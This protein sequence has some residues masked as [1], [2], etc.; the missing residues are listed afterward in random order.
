[1]M[2]KIQHPWQVGPTELIE[3]ALERMHNGEDFDRRLAF[4][5][6]DVGVETL[7]KTYLTLPDGVTQFQIKRSERYAAVDGN[8]HELL[9]GVQSANPKKASVINFA[10]IEHYH[11]LRNTLYHQGNQVTAV[12]LNQLDGYAKLAVNLLREYLDVNLSPKLKRPFSAGSV[13]T[14]NKDGHEPE[15]RRH[16]TSSM[17]FAD[18]EKK[19]K[20]DEI[21]I[22][23]HLYEFTKQN[24]S[25]VRMGTGA[26]S[27]SFTFI[28]IRNDTSGS[29]FSV[30]SNGDFTVNLGYLGKVCSQEE[31]DR[32]RNRIAAIPSL[33]D[34][35]TTEKYYFTL[36][37]STAFSRPEFLEQFKKE[38]LDLKSAL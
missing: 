11:N 33:A 25:E 20:K 31:V 24:A 8:F 7:F 22:V 28:L 23:N 34:I 19:L 16:W 18:A 17:F 15:G 32:F 37:S 14:A 13:G 10:Y 35:K 36:K 30:Y 4:L 26:E 27:G 3:F 9:R 21:K 2:I 12:P 6:L 38:V 5:I 1:M 29:V